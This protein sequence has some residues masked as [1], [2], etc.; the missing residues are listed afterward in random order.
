MELGLAL[1][2]FDDNEADRRRFDDFVRSTRRRHWQQDITDVYRVID[3]IA[4]EDIVAEQQPRHGW[5][6][7]VAVACAQAGSATS[8]LQSKSRNHKVARARRLIARIAHDE[9]RVTPAEISRRLN[10]SQSAVSRMLNIRHAHE[11]R[12]VEAVKRAWLRDATTRRQD[13]SV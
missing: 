9:L 8:A 2:G 13:V 12:A 3:D 1:C 11:A 10:V 6:D 4:L 7:L 5:D